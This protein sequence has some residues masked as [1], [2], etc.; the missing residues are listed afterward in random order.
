MQTVQNG[1]GDVRRLAEAQWAAARLA[2][3]YQ[4]LPEGISKAMLLDRFERAAPRLGFGDGIVRLV[5]ALVRVT[6]E[7]DWTGKTHPIAWPS[8]DM[9]GEELQRSRTVIQGLIR[10]AVRAGL[11]HMKDSGNGKRWGYRGER[12]QIIEAF[13]FDLSPL[14]VRWDEFADLAAARS[15]EQDQRRHLKRKLGEVRREIRTVCADALA[16]DLA[17]FDWPRAIAEAS[18]RLPRTPA[19]GELE[20]LLDRFGQ[21][22]AAVD[23]AWVRGRKSSESEPR[24]LESRAHKEP[25]T[26]PRSERA[27]Y[28]AHQKEVAERPARASFDREADGL[29]AAEARINEEVI[30]LSLVLEAAPE[31]HAHLDD[32]AGAE[33][34]DLVD[35]VSR[36]APLMGINVSALREAR[37]TL[38]RNR[39]A[40]A[41]VTVL[42]RWKDGEITSSAGGYLRAMCERERIGAL[43]LLPSLYGLKERH[44]PRRSGRGKSAPGR[45]ER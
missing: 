31:I 7:Q 23:G 34:E 38:G 29:E 22:L 10:T 35:A 15:R 25:T 13:G 11:V 14:A 9:L 4:G 8:N 40:I 5:R 45:M 30:P 44:T 27:T 18:G 26:Q 21:L 16:Q 33:W 3:A 19:L 32:P 17:G 12:G 2:D 6:Q 36:V 41:V 43:H 24:G 28:L 37:Q 20:A 42:A 1:T 39:A